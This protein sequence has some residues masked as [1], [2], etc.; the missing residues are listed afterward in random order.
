MIVFRIPALLL[1]VPLLPPQA[2]ASPR[3][4]SSV[5][6]EDALSIVFP[7]HIEEESFCYV[8]WL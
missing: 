3:A 4:A 7:C 6:P 1:A 8:W 5:C 2:L